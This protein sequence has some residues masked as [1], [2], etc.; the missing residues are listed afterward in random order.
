MCLFL[1]ASELRVIKSIEE[2]KASNL[3]AQSIRNGGRV[4][5]P[6]Y[7]TT[8]CN[9]VIV[10]LNQKFCLNFNFSLEG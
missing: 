10:K 2:G 8:L 3:V 4:I 1:G 6:Q 7:K 9:Q 5:S